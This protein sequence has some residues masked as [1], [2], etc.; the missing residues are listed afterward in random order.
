HGVYPREQV[1]ADG[2]WWLQPEAALLVPATD[3]VALTLTCPPPNFLPRPVR[4][5][6]TWEG[7]ETPALVCLI[8]PRQTVRVKIPGPESA[9]PFGSLLLRLRFSAAFRPNHHAGEGK[10]IRDLAL[11]LRDLQTRHLS[12]A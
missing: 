11:Q 10:D 12:S 5:E 2:Y 8:A 6:A 3:A 9:P 4:I 1:G 7:D